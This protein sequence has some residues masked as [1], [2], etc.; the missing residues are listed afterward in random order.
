[1]NAFNVVLEEGIDR[2]YV[3]GALIGLVLFFDGCEYLMRSI[4]RTDLHI[5]THTLSAIGM[6]HTSSP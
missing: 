1:M 4:D 6:N 5:D 3:A 2:N